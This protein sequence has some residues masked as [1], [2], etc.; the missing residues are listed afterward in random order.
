M[1]CFV[2][3]LECNRMKRKNEIRI[4]KQI[5]RAAI[6]GLIAA[7]YEIGVSYEGCGIFPESHESDYTPFSRSVSEVMKGVHAC[8]EE[9]LIARTDENAQQKFVW[10][11]WGNFADIISDYSMSLEPALAL[12]EKVA[13][14]YS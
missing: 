3:G 10:L 6:K 7:G 11:V 8:D 12:A 13:E 1:I 14:R 4:E 5:V 2:F 9:W